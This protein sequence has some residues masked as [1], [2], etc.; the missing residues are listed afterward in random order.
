MRC[1]YIDSKTGIRCPLKI[2]IKNT[3]KAGYGYCYNHAKK[4]GLIPEEELARTRELACASARKRRARERKE[5]ETGIIDP[6]NKSIIASQKNLRNLNKR[7]EKIMGLPRFDMETLMK[8]YKE[9]GK[10]VEDL[11]LKKSLF[12]QWYVADEESRMPKEI[13]DICGILKI[14]MINL[15]DWTRSPWF[16][17]KL[18]VERSRIY[19]LAASKI[20][21]VNIIKACDESDVAIKEFF[22]Q[23]GNLT[24]LLGEMSGE[25]KKTD[26]TENLMNKMAEANTSVKGQF[27]EEISNMSDYLGSNVTRLKEGI[28]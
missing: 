5:K 28:G 25:V 2:V 7:F 21:K 27:D 9:M 12:V 3:Q 20:D 8:A 24:E 17:N 23:I 11:D 15:I 13:K 18:N 22:R 1:K 26:K 6:K 4:K 16:V 19:I 14:K 10:D